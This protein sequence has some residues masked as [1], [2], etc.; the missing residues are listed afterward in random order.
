MFNISGKIPFVKPKLDDDKVLKICQTCF[1]CAF[2]P[3]LYV[4]LSCAEKESE[5]NA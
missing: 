1:S 4:C 2:C 5:D 3:L